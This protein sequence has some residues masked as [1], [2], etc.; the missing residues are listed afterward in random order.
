MLALMLAVDDD[1]DLPSA[2]A[3]SEY[4]QQPMSNM[5]NRRNINYFPL[6]NNCYYA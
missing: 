5:L 3:E 1:N 6:D 4:T 2:T